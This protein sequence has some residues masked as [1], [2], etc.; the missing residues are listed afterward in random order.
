MATRP[1]D[2][3]PRPLVVVIHSW[4]MSYH[5]GTP[6]RFA[7]GSFGG[8]DFLASL[9]GN[10]RGLSRIAM[11][12]DVDAAHAAAPRERSVAPLLFANF[13]AQRSVRAPGTHSK[14]DFAI[15]RYR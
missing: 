14:R 7:V 4:V 3:C 15:A 5:R 9:H 13:G 2:V 11:R 1:W 12:A 8:A 10:Q 6:I